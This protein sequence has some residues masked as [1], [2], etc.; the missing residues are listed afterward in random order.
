M[1]G[2]IPVRQI[3]ET[4]FYRSETFTEFNNFSGIQDMKD[5]E[6]IVIAIVDDALF[7]PLMWCPKK[8]H[9]TPALGEFMAWWADEDPTQFVLDMQDLYY[10]EIIDYAVLTINKFINEIV[11]DKNP[12]LVWYTI[13]L[14]D[15]LVIEKGNDFRI[16]EF[17][18]RYASGKWKI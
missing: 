11:R 18:R 15:S 8:D 3:A 1:Y 12:W 10:E 4:L 2:I 9:L 13:R 6:T 5:A 17:D 14:G 7:S 16:L